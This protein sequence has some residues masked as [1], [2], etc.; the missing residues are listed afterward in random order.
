[1]GAVR[2]RGEDTERLHSDGLGG[3][4]CG[5]WAGSRG[6]AHRAEAGSATARPPELCI[7]IGC[8]ARRPVA[9]EA[10]RV[11]EDQV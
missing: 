4:L 8:T 10:L 7:E 9:A 3:L 11:Q 5:G 2:S 6:A 1:M